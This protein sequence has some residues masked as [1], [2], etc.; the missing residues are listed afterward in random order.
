MLK[1]LRITTLRL[2]S[3]VALL[4]LVPSFLIRSMESRRTSLQI[5]EETKRKKEKKEKN[6]KTRW[7]S[8]SL[9]L[10]LLPIIVIETKRQMDGYERG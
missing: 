7:C 4:L 5:E 6:N 8:T 1:C 9:L 10:L 2:L 3:L